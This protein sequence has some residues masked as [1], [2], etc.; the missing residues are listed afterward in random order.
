MMNRKAIFSARRILAALMLLAL[1]VTGG[2]PGTAAAQTT[3][4]VVR[5]GWYD[6]VFNRTDQ[7]GRKSGY[8]Y[9]YQQRI[10]I[11]TGWTYEYV[12]G[13][14][15]EL[16]EKL[17]AGELDLLSDVSYTEERADQMLYSAEAMDRKGII[18]LLR[19]RIRRSGRTIFPR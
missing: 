19:R 13:S 5:V 2:S 4:K 3:E 8:A 10:A 6:S 11:Y 14:W 16:L 1:I 15:P 12:E 18:S 17:I 7:F 9:E